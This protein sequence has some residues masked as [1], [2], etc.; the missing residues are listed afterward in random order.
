MPR[1]GRMTHRIHAGSSWA[2]RMDEADTVRVSL[3]LGSRS[4]VIPPP[5]TGPAVGPP[6]LCPGGRR[7]R[8]D[9]VARPARWLWPGRGPCGGD[10][11]QPDCMIYG[12]IMLV[13]VVGNGQG[14]MYF[15]LYSTHMCTYTYMMYTHIYFKYMHVYCSDRLASVRPDAHRAC[16]RT[17]AIQSNL[18]S[19]PLTPGY[20]GQP[21][22]KFTT[23]L[24]QVLSSARNR[25]HNRSGSNKF[26]ICKIN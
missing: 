25:S 17:K 7:R 18:A 14:Y 13:E 15:Y 24:A 5:H 23:F 9:G 19:S 2:W 21:G 10:V 3:A 4:L 22:V 1:P 8:A 12:Q 6:L 26:K 20:R 16:G 11:P